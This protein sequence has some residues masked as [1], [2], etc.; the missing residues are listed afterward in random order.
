MDVERIFLE[1]DISLNEMA[2]KLNVTP[3]QLSQFINE[4]YRMRFNYFI[5][6]YR[7]DGAKEILEKNM[8]ANIIS[9]AFHVGFSSKSSF[10]KTFKQFTGLT[11]TEYKLNY[12]KL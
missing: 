11:P 10:N 9:V 6:K 5:N 7:I 12:R 3:H 2:K 4:H 1:P 8:D